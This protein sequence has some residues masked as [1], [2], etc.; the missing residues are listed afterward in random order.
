MATYNYIV[1]CS[2]TV[3]VPDDNTQINVGNTLYTLDPTELWADN[4]IG[5]GVIILS[6]EIDDVKDI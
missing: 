5:D 2:V 4:N 1:Q 3:E 6:A